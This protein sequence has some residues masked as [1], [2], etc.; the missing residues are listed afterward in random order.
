MF[1]YNSIIISPPDLL[2]QR[3]SWDSV[4]NSTRW[5]INWFDFEGNISEIKKKRN[6]LSHFEDCMV[7]ICRHI[8]TFAKKK[9]M[10]EI[11][12]RNQKYK[13]E[14]FLKWGEELKSKSFCWR[15]TF[16]SLTIK[17]SLNCKLKSAWIAANLISCKFDQDVYSYLEGGYLPYL[18][19]KKTFHSHEILVE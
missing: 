11:P 4:L 12:S 8:A 16:P 15:S 3:T 6:W 18:I 17:F 19:L 10:I 1:L 2:E 13:G 7:A 9:D 14:L 5:D